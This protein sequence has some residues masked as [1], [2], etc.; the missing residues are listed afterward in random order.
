MEITSCSI[1]ITVNYLTDRDR[2]V[3]L[4][5]YAFKIKLNE[6]SMEELLP[7]ETLELLSETQFQFNEKI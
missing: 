2:K 3:A 6:A 5:S 7:F 1:N 4:Y